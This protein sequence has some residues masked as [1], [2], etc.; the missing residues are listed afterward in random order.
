MFYT[1]I[2]LEGD[3]IT[4]NPTQITSIEWGLFC[5]STQELEPTTITLTSGKA[6]DIDHSDQTNQKLFINLIG[7][8]WADYIG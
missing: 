1:I 6:I 3:F 5:E 7:H 4:I 2:N 8:N